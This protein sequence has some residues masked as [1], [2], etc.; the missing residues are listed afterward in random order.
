M[1][2]ARARRQQRGRACGAPPHGTWHAGPRAAALTQDRFI[3]VYGRKP[4]LEAL[5]DP[6]LDVDKVIVADNARGPEIRDI[7]RPRGGAGSRCS[8]RR[9]SGSRYSPATAG[10]TRGARRCRRPRMQRLVTA[11]E[12]DAVGGTVLILDGITTRPMSG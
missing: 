10:T 2:S 12:A 4:V 3:T 1:S 9:R 6:A 11:L 8:R 5:A 7:E